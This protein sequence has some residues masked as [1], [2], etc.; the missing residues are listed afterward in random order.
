MFFFNQM[1][2]RTL[3]DDIQALMNLGH[4]LD[5]ATEQATEDRALRFAGDY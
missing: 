4:P 5:R 1:A 2:Q 3:A